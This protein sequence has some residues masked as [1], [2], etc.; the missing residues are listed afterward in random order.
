MTARREILIDAYNVIF[1]D[2]KLGPLVRQDAERARNEF[3]AFV[4]PQIPAAIEQRLADSPP[5]G[6]L[7]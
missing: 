2:P 6:S 7:S 1:A 3:L 4:A 5:S